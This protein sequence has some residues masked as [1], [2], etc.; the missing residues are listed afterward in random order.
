MS[1]ETR[2][3]AVSS[4]NGNN[5][6]SHT[7]PD[8]YVRTNDPYRLA[9]LAMVSGFKPSF[10]QAAADACEVDGEA[11]YTISAVIYNPEDVDPSE[12]PERECNCGAEEND[13]PEHSEECASLSEDNDDSMSYSDANGAWQ[14]I[15]VFPEESPNARRPIYDS[16]EECFDDDDLKLVPSDM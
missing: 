12:T 9:A 4:G 5:G 6:V 1:D 10:K 11:D 3:Y 16:L 14:I 13:L 15:E 8:Y 2:V 7:F